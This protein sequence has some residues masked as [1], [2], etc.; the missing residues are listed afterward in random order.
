M[1]EGEHPAVSIGGGDAGAKLDLGIGK[2][3]CERGARREAGRGA[4]V[5]LVG[6]RRQ[7]DFDAGEA[8]LA[9]I[10]QR[11]AS[12]IGDRTNFSR[13]GKLEE[14][15]A[16]WPALRMRARHGQGDRTSHAAYPRSACRSDVPTPAHGLTKRLEWGG[17]AAIRASRPAFRRCS[18]RIYGAR[19]HASG[20]VSGPARW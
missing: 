8:N 4:C 15:A 5:A 13:T 7:R 3:R 10:C 6:A 19:G 20:A 2:H 16:R 18:G 9:P 1:D 14:A 11:E 12:A 17:T